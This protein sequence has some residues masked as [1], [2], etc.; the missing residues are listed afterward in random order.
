MATRAAMCHL[1]RVREPCSIVQVTS[2]A[3]ATWQRLD[4]AGRN[5]TPRPRALA[6]Q[7]R[8][9]GHALD[10]WHDLA[11]LRQGERLARHPD[12][13]RDLGKAVPVDVRRAVAGA[14]LLRQYSAAENL[15][16]FSSQ[17]HS[18]H[19]DRR[20]SLDVLTPQR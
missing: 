11:A 5:A 10:R 17:A 18:G 9:G 1:D 12:H 4:H 16:S 8:A 13:L 19:E 7:R 14:R 2:T 20:I 3:C 6:G 15:G